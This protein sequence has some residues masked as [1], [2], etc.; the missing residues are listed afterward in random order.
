MTTMNTTARGAYD[1]NL[2]A[3]AHRLYPDNGCKYGGPSCLT[4]PLEDCVQDNPALR[5]ALQARVKRTYRPRGSVIVSTKEVR[6]PIS[7]CKGDLVRI[8]DTARAKAVRG[9]VGVALEDMHLVV[10]TPN[11]DVKVRVGDAVKM[12]RTS[13]LL[14]AS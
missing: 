11:Y 10:G 8:S 12:M 2:D 6:E 13:N 7:V 14:R 5:R 9:M 3:I 4:C 1:T